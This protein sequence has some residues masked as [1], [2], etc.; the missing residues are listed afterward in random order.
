V[1]KLVARGL[2]VGDRPA[3]E[4]F[5]SHVNCYRLSAYYRP[6]YVSPEV[7]APGTTFEQLRAIYEFDREL[8]HLVGR[9][10]ETIEVSLRT[11][12]AYQVGSAYG[13]FGHVDPSNFWDEF[14]TGTV[15][16]PLSYAR[17][18]DD[19]LKETTRSKEE[20]VRHFREKYMEFP[21]LPVWTA[22][23]LMSMG[24]LSVMYYGLKTKEK[25][26]IG[27]ACRLDRAP[28]VAVMNR[29]IELR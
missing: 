6:F 28:F 8:R 16:A 1:D 7:F 12:I 19:V 4:E 9:A 21:N 15:T 13:A 2:V 23:E 14:V 24:T 29:D 10:L 3:A 27:S 5:L 25:R 22:V 26:G 11:S 20:F 17:R 18:H